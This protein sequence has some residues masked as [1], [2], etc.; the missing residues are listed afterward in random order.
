MTLRPGL[1]ATTY[2]SLG[3]ALLL[4]PRFVASQGT[5]SVSSGS[6]T[7]ANAPKDSA[8]AKTAAKAPRKRKAL[9]FTGSLGYTQT[10]GN[11]TARNFNVG[12]SLTYRLAGWT[13]KQDLTFVYGEAN[14][15]VNANF[16]NG[17]LRG[18]RNVAERV[19]FF[20]ASRY[21]RNVRQ[22]VTN[23]FQQGF[24][25]NMLAF[26]D[27]RNKV[28]VA[29]GGS[30]F[31]QQLE[32]GAVAK[33][34]RAFPAARAA[35]D[36][37]Y[38]FTPVAYLQQTAEYLPAVGDTA[39][40]YFVNTESAIVAPISRNVGLKIGYVIRYNSEPPVRDNI[41]LRTTDMFFSS[42]LTL[43]F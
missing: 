41:P 40:S 35:L 39:T 11:S 22:G 20:L 38:R 32:P 26:E 5:S 17:G 43:T 29:L 2:V 7:T 24:G 1:A 36:Y 4:A 30:L 3:L 28:H 18:D 14:D 25:L 10:G 8:G 23:R 12:N 9:D 16:W 19:D 42:G 27:S 13:I 31:S 6:P 33:V 34:S 21:D 37:R 15:R